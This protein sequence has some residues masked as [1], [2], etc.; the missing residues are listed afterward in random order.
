MTTVSGANNNVSNYAD[1]T[2]NST[3]L[4]QNEFLKLLVTQLQY[5][6]PLSPLSNEDFIAQLAQFSTLESMENL[7]KMFGGTQAYNLIGNV[8]LSE[9]PTTLETKSGYV[10]GVKKYNGEYFAIISGNKEPMPKED[11]LKAFDASG[12]FFDTYKEQLFKEESLITD[13]LIWKESISSLEDIANIL[14]FAE[15]EKLPASIKNLW[16]TSN[17]IEVPV[18][19]VNYVYLT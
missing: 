14:G 6:D 7:E 12:I 2:Q 11:V 9:D 8:I 19:Q 17:Q 1:S 10:I 16:I 4:G 15:A 13:N 3:K 5:Q 18:D